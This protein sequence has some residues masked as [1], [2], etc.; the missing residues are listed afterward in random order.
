MA[1]L[2]ELFGVNVFGDAA[3]RKRLPKETYK[4]LHKTIADGRPLDGA[5]ASNE[6]NAEQDR[7]IEKGEPH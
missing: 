1:R 6:A 7:A 3:M 4:A 5:M 2:E